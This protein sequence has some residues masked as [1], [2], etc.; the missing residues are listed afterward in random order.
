[1]SA[2]PASAAVG[3][4]GAGTMGAG[5]AQVAA[6]AGHPVLLYDAAEGAAE[7]GRAG[8]KAALDRRVAKGRLAAADADAVLA[9]IALAGR[10]EDLAPARLVIEAVVERL[11]VKQAVLGRVEA[12]AGDEIILAS[13]TS[14]LSITAIAAG[15]RRPRRLVGMHFFNPAPVMELVEVVSGAATDPGVAAT[16]HATAAAWGKAPVHAR[17]TPGFIVNRV[18]RPFYAEAL[19]VVQEGAADP[20]TVDA[21]MT[22]CGGFRMGPFALMDLIGHDVN[23]AVTASVFAAFHHDRRYAPSLV[24]KELVEAGWLGRKSGRG[25]Y[26][27]AEGASAPPPATA[28]AAPPPGAVVVHG[29]TPLDERIAAS[30][31]AP[32]R[33][34]GDGAIRVDGVLLRPSDGRMATEVAAAQGCADVAV[35]D[36]ALDMAGARRIAVAVAEQS[37]PGTAAKAAGFF[38]GLG[39]DVSP[40]ADTPGLIVTRTVAALANEA[41]EAVLHGVATPADIDLAMTKG[42]NYPRGPLAWAEEIGL[43]KLLAVLENLFAATRDERYRPSLL[44][45]RKALGGTRFHG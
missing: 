37:A 31:L 19:R 33:A 29:A 9:R 32:D 22:E 4:I 24:Q 20:A 26:S 36:L 30:G 5:I 21:V 44:L 2:L 40:V 17:S 15:L 25:F 7:R 3:V 8:I 12:A 35:Y 42:V 16:V 27:Y 43:A 18:A 14:S 28:P 23:Y 13:N 6:Q 34:A 41:A 10:P 1:M 38:Q 39:L 45:R 11:D